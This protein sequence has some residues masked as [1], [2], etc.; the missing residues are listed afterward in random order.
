MVTTGDP[1]FWESP[2]FHEDAAREADNQ[3]RH[4]GVNSE[5]CVNP[6]DRGLFQSFSTIE[7]SLNQQEIMGLQLLDGMVAVSFISNM[8]IPPQ[9]PRQFT[10]ISWPDPAVVLWGSRVV[11]LHDSL[12]L[13]QPRFWSGKMCRCDPWEFLQHGSRCIKMAQWETTYVYI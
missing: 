7:H 12:H 13:A 11:F 10:Y 2:R 3:K 5:G 1:P 9:N 8:T 6:L 4:W